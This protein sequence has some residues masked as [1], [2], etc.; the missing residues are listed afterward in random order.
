MQD[1]ADLSAYDLCVFSEWWRPGIQERPVLI[2]QSQN[3]AE[4][5]RMKAGEQT[6]GN[7]EGLETGK[8]AFHLILFPDLFKN[9]MKLVDPLFRKKK[10]HS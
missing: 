9:L 8:Q 2:Y 10:L 1:A 3:A 4:P 7:K 6:P 5:L